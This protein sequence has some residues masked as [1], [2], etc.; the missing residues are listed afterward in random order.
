MDPDAGGPPGSSDAAALKPGTRLWSQ[1]GTAAVI[2][3]RAPADGSAGLRCA[4]EPMVTEAPAAPSAEMAAD[5]ERLKLGKRYTDLAG[6]LEL[7]CTTAGL[8]P[9]TLDGVVLEIKAAR[10]LPASD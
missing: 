3:V 2:V 1:V 8:G 9:L 4:G 7:V 6:R 5:A 10:A